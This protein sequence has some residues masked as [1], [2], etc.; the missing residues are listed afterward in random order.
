MLGLSQSQG[1]LMLLLHEIVSCEILLWSGPGSNLIHEQ[2]L[3]PLLCFQYPHLGVSKS[4]MGIQYVNTSARLGFQQRPS[5]RQ[6][7]TELAVAEPGHNPFL[8]FPTLILHSSS[9]TDLYSVHSRL[10][11]ESEGSPLSRLA[12]SLP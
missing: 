11:R 2:I 8:T 3:V 4:F 1:A 7:T 12:H 9:S 10:K 6:T 5:R